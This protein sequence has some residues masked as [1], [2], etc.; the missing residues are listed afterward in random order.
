MK[1]IKVLKFFIKIITSLIGFGLI[2]AYN[3][4]NLQEPVV[5]LAIIY[6][7]LLDFFTISLVGYIKNFFTIL[8]RKLGDFFDFS[9]FTVKAD[10]KSKPSI[11]KNK[12]NRPRSYDLDEDNYHYYVDK[13]I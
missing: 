4:L 1:I 11:P 12:I 13:K 2:L 7:K 5:Y 9:E 6:A 8:F 3:D 10:S